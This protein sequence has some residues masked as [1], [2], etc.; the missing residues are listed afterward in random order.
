MSNIADLIEEYI[1]RQLAQQ[2]DGKVELRRTDIADQI[3][4]APSQISYVLST[5]FTHDKGFVVESR[6]GLGGYIRIVQV[7]LKNLVYEDMLGKIYEDTTFGEVQGMVRYLMQ[8]E[9]ITNRE[10]ALAMQV[11]TG[12][13]QSK[14]M[15]IEERIRMIKSLFLTM[16]NFSPT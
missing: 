1:L 10:A 14:S 9:M 2:Q 12:V 5:R 11:V 8:R 4:C 16:K 13:F 6:R 3:S 7:P 15:A